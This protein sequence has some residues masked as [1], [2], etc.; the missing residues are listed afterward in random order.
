MPSKFGGL[1]VVE[2]SMAGPRSR[3]GGVPVDVPSEPVPVRDVPQ[4]RP[5]LADRARKIYG[6]RAG[7]L[8]RISAGAYPEQTLPEDILQ[9]AGQVAGGIGEMAGEAIVSGVKAITPDPVEEF[10]AEKASELGDTELAKQGMSMIGEGVDAYE[11]WRTENPRVARDVESVV[12]IGLFGIP[13]AKAAVRGAKVAAPVAKKAFK[14]KDA[15]SIDTIRIAEKA[16][17]SKM[18][19]DAKK[20]GTTIKGVPVNKNFSSILDD[21]MKS[22]SLRIIDPDVHPHS[23][24]ALNKINE[25]T[26]GPRQLTPSSIQDTKEII[27][28]F[29]SKSMDGFKE[30]K[31]TLRLY[32]IKDAFDE[33]IDKLQ[34]KDFIKGDKQFYDTWKE[35]RR[36]SGLR[37]K[38]EIL[39]KAFYNAG[40]A[41]K[42]MNPDLALKNEFRRIAKNDKLMKRFNDEEKFY[43]RRAAKTGKL[44]GMLEKLSGLSPASGKIGVVGTTMFGLGI[45]PLT[46]AATGTVGEVA[47]RGSGALAKRPSR[48]AVEAITKQ[49]EETK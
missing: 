2:T 8:E 31:D 26:S 18:D 19:A 14:G 23:V 30:T 16:L 22:G 35:A 36:V 33:S 6:E 48:K 7:E 32:A 15:P 42:N 38:G 12:N 46:A 3:F 9:T 45:D 5:N 17:W 10:V 25:R 40:F 4:Q 21:K 47:R 1:E 11:T 43:I 27:D 49:L 44:E 29:I 37:Y 24:A 34:P 20:G 28:G 39:E 13:A 41:A